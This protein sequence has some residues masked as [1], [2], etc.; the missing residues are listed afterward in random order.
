MPLDAIARVWLGAAPDHS[1]RATVSARI[2][3][4]KP[5]RVGE[6]AE[7]TL[8]LRTVVGEPLLLKDLRE[9]HTEKIHLLVVDATLTDYHH[10]HPVPTDRPGEYAFRFTPRRP[11]SYRA[12]ADLQP[13]LTGLQEYAK[14][15]VAAPTIAAPAVEKA[16]PQTGTHGPFTYELAFDPPRPKAGTPAT[17]TVYVTRDGKPFKGLE[18]LMAA[19][20]HLVGFHEDGQVVLHMHPAET[21]ALVAEDRGGPRLSFRL[22]AETPGFYRLFVQVQ[23]GGRSQFIPFGV[24]VVP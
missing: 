2:C 19:F 10:E 13:L 4:E 24:D 15:E 11:G 21:R 1:K 7:A 8:R 22:F 16:Y 3:T 9:V 5:L 6:E 23:I 18:P 17:G 12:F 14:A 20:A